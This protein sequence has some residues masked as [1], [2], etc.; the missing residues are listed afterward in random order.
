MPKAHDK[1]VIECWLQLYSR[2]F[3]TAYA[4]VDWPDSDSSK[5]NIDAICRDDT[6]KVLAVEHTLIQPFEGEKRDTASF[7]ETLAGLQNHPDLLEQG[8]MITA[9][10][11]VGSFPTG[12]DW[13]PV[14]NELL[15]QLKSVLPSLP[16][17][18]GSVTIKGANWTI[19]LQIDKMQTQPNDPGKFLTS[20]IWPGDPGPELVIKAIKDKIPKLSRYASAKKIL[21][22]EQDSRAGMTHSQFE[23]LPADPS[24]KGLLGLIDEVWWAGT[25]CLESEEVIFTDQVWPRMRTNRCSLDL[26]TGKFRRGPC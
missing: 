6:A 20:R 22:F 25:M 26:R 8:Y 10:Q 4:V 11:P 18:L 19:D 15:G 21:L 9:S 2:I 3:G 13:N 5:K 23:Q 1:Y 16:P 12:V 24:V 17:G 14:R 7:M